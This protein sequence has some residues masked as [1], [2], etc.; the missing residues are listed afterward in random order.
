M[1]FWDWA[2][3]SLMVALLY[4]GVGHA[5]FWRWYLE[6]KADGFDFLKAKPPFWLGH[7]IVFW[8]IVYFWPVC[9]YLRWRYAR[10]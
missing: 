3:T 1:S 7:E 10:R 2:F 6:A 5:L 4:G 8:F 9:V